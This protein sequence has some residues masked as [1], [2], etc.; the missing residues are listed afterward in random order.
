MAWLPTAPCRAPAR[1]SLLVLLLVLVL[2]LE[3]SVLVLVL[4]CW[5]LDT[6]LPGSP[7]KSCGKLACEVLVLVRTG[8]WTLSTG[9]SAGTPTWPVFKYIS[10]T[11]TGTCTRTWSTGSGNGLLS[12]WYKSAWNAQEV[13]KRYMCT[14]RG[15]AAHPD[16][17]GRLRRGCWWPGGVEELCADTWKD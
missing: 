13:P 8:T 6:S 4:V 11:G 5:V 2:V 9:T 3:L 15:R 7:R 12:T 1:M 14:D 17:V 16:D 10:G